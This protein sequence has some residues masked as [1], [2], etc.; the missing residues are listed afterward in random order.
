MCVPFFRQNTAPSPALSTAAWM[1]APGSTAIAPGGHGTSVTPAAAAV[2]AREMRINKAESDT[3]IRMASDQLPA[4]SETAGLWFV[5]HPSG[6]IRRKAEPDRSS[7]IQRRSQTG[8]T[9]R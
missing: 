8:T 2:D 6:E 3:E 7:R 4:R 5:I 1:E 9:T